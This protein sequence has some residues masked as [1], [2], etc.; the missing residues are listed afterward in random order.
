MISC[1]IIEDE[2]P[3]REELK[4]FIKNTSSFELQGEF[5]SSEEAL[6]FL[7]KRV[8]DVIFMDINIPGINGMVLSKIIKN[9][10]SMPQIVFITAHKE[11]AV[12]AFEIEAFDYIL[13]P[14]SEERIVKALK[15]LETHFNEKNVSDIKNERI[16]LWKNDKMIVVDVKD[17]IYCEASERETIITTKFDIF[18]VNF[19]FSEFEKKLPVDIFFRCH[20]SYIVNLTLIDEIIPWFNGTLMIRFNK[21]KKDVPVS[22][23]NVKD[24]KNLMGLI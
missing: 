22:K 4:Y 13:K 9:L 15:K 7:G 12:E 19:T 16:S 1:I 18:N 6:Q 10:N 17:I 5:E 14:Y 2:Y 23:K 21:L 8:P 20:R 11:H 3:A 24:F